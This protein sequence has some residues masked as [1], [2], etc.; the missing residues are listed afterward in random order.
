M[1]FFK[2][3]G[4]CAGVIAIAWIYAY[5]SDCYVRRRT[6][7]FDHS[8]LGEVSC[9]KYQA[10]SWVVADEYGLAFQYY[11]PMPGLKV[12]EEYVD[13]LQSFMRNY[14]SLKATLGKCA[15]FEFQKEFSSDKPPKLEKD[16][17]HLEKMIRLYDHPEMFLN[18]FELQEISALEAG[19]EFQIIYMCRKE[20]YEG[21]FIR[22]NRNLEI[23][24]S[25]IHMFP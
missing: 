6:V 16:R 9:Y 25:G 13:F 7:K 5:L 10:R 14:T 22:L 23:I 21:I 24:S 12:E 8:Y 20:L 18:E 1:D 4:C 15:I 2:I 3:F 19:A 17:I 11:F